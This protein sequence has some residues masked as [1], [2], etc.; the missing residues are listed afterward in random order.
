MK[1]KAQ[2]QSNEIK[3]SNLRLEGWTEVYSLLK[4]SAETSN[5]MLA[6]ELK[7]ICDLYTLH[8]L[9]GGHFDGPRAWAHVVNLLKGGKRTEIDK[10]YYRTAEHLQRSRPGRFRTARRFS[11]CHVLHRSSS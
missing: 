6:R 5:P 9:P 1:I 2:N 10:D 4:G 8:G 11:A 7:L 3:R